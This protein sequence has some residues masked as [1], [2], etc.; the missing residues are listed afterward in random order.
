[1]VLVQEDPQE[2]DKF[3]ERKKENTENLVEIVKDTEETETLV[4]TDQSESSEAEVE[5]KAVT[6]ATE[7]ELDSLSEEEEDQEVDSEAAT[8]EIDPDS[9]VVKEKENSPISHT[10]IKKDQETKNMTSDPDK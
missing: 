10:E 8:M 4:R 2:A 6:Q 3:I 1:M 9:K 7:I 5:V